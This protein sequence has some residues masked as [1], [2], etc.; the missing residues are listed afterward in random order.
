MWVRGSSSIG[1]YPQRFGL[2]EEFA[3]LV[4]AVLENTFINAETIRLDAGAR[5]P[6]L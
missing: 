6:R 3:H 5:M 1:C 2:P 4:A